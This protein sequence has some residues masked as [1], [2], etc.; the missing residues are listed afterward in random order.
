MNDES[1]RFKTEERILTLCKSQSRSLGELAEE[2]T[3]NK[4]TLRAGYL[5]PMTKAGKLKRST[6]LPFKSGSRYR[7]A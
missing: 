1:A 7:T 6:E 5:Y 4:N 2:L 3:M